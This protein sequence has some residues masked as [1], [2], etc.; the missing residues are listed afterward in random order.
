M[1]RAGYEMEMIMRLCG[2]IRGFGAKSLKMT[3]WRDE[4]TIT[5]ETGKFY[6]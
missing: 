4:Y 6:G 5:L 1:F 2:K 3:I